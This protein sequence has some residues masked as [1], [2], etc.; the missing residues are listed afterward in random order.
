MLNPFNWDERMTVYKLML[1][2]TRGPFASSNEE[3][4]EMNV[5][6]GLPIQ[7]AWQLR[8]GRLNDFHAF[9]IRVHNVMVPSSDKWRVRI[10]FDKDERY[11]EPFETDKT[12]RS[13]KFTDMYFGFDEYDIRPGMTVEV[14]LEYK[15]LLGFW[16]TW[17]KP[18]TYTFKKALT[19]GIRETAVINLVKKGIFSDD[20]ASVF[21]ETLQFSSQPSTWELSPESWWG[22]MNYFLCVIPYLGGVDAGVLPD[23]E[24]EWPISNQDNYCTSVEGCKLGK[25]GAKRAVELWRDTFNM[26]RQYDA[27]P[28]GYHLDELKRTIWDAH[29][30]SIH[31]SIVFVTGEN[32][33]YSYLEKRVS[34]GWSNFVEFIATTWFNCDFP[35]IALLQPILPQ[36]KLTPEN[37]L[38]N[39][40]G[41]TTKQKA[42][43]ATLVFL[44]ELSQ[45]NPCFEHI[46]QIWR[47]AMATPQGR[48]DG[49]RV[50]E[51]T[52]DDP[53]T[54]PRNMG[55]LIRDF[56]HARG[57]FDLAKM[58]AECSMCVG[59]I[60]KAM[61][62]AWM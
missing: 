30:A 12:H 16:S 29:T 56:Y 48:A 18:I 44:F 37:S 11:S 23:I 33:L 34:L 24:F 57:I 39:L 58:A 5:F 62:E 8:S 40:P 50:M 36:Q 45:C 53:S 4:D 59:D 2:Y 41:L 27:S 13:P 6:W 1:Q 60:G 14:G 7:L 9:T 46:F 32:S 55:A 54:L 3:F 43:V 42:G 49:R 20:Y 52:F 31:T 21:L 47:D 10:V 15:N 28:T 22:V 61:W 17:G 25:F 19:N 26:F 35:T 38:S 51:Q